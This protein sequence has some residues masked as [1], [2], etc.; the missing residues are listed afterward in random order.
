MTDDAVGKIITAVS[1]PVPFQW[2]ASGAAEFYA[3]R[4]AVLHKSQGRL[5]L[6]MG[7]KE[8]YFGW[9]VGY[10]YGTRSDHQ[11]AE[12]WVQFWEAVEDVGVREIVIEW[13]SSHVSQTT[14]NELHIPLAYWHGNKQV[15]F[16]AK[17]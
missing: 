14:A 4:Q 16:Y 3:A 13:I 6:I 2:Q 7:F 1:G 17:R 11:Y 10:P 15:Y 8:T 9:Q 12:L 5:H